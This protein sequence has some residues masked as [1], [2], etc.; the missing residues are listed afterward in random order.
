MKHNKQQHMPCISSGYE[1]PYLPQKWS[2]H[3]EA[4]STHNCYTYMNNDLFPF[5]RTGN[6]PQPGRHAQLEAVKKRNNNIVEAYNKLNELNCVNVKQK[7]MLD[8]GDIVK[9]IPLKEGQSYIPRKNHYK[10]F[11]MVSPN[12]DY[13]F[14]RMD[15]HMI[16]VYNIIHK[17]IKSG[18]LKL[19]HSK[20]ELIK[21]YVEHMIKHIP[22]VMKLTIQNTQNKNLK[23]LL[24]HGIKYSKLWSHKPGATPVINKDGNGKY[25]INPLNAS[26][27]F[28][29]KGGIN[30]NKNC[31]FFEIPVNSL[32]ATRSSGVMTNALNN[33]NN[34]RND[35]G[36]TS[37]HHLHEG[38]L[39]TL[40]NP[41]HKRTY[42]LKNYNE[43][44]KFYS[45]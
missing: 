42:H 43:Y 32:K 41:K 31:C 34:T 23:D 17:K 25:I 27:D 40:L 13:H 4:L 7:V 1:P 14:A 24:R 28:S 9:L 21:L 11:L 19:P 8:N 35:I 5:G 36:S 18:Q 20:K 37:I 29:S 39:L 44:L 30:Y 16:K 33:P 15:N 22:Y 12:R 6:K 45:Y 26:W 38:F 2:E 3:D 10:G